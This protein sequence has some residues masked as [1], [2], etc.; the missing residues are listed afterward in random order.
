MVRVKSLVRLPVPLTVVRP[1]MGIVSAVL[2]GTH[3]IGI[4]IAFLTGSWPVLLNIPPVRVGNN[5][6]L[7][8]LQ[9]T[10]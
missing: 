5:E 6:Y 4:V 10:S 8:D 2:T 7:F 3:L 9:V 1:I